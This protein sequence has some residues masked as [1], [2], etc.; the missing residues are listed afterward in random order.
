MQNK[1]NKKSLWRDP[2]NHFRPP[3]SPLRVLLRFSYLISF[4]FLCLFMQ[5]VPPFAS[6]WKV[7]FER[8][9]ALLRR[10]EWRQFSY[11]RRFSPFKSCRVSALIKTFKNTS[12]CC[13]MLKSKGKQEF[14]CPHMPVSNIFSELLG[15]SFIKIAENYH[16]MYIYNLLIFGVDL[17]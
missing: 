7:L 3:T 17:I 10:S 14:L 9:G 5:R 11:P 16:L 6:R 8:P 4:L 1:L 15:K 12:N 2:I 13:L